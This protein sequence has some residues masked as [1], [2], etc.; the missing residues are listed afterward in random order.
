MIWKNVKCIVRNG[1]LNVFYYKN[2]HFSYE[3]YFY[4]YK[5]VFN[6][7]C[8]WIAMY[9]KKYLIL[10]GRLSLEVKLGLRIIIITILFTIIQK[11]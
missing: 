11:K 4:Y 8:L 1:F 2:T 5:N 6:L 7:Y 3:S 9:S 10:I